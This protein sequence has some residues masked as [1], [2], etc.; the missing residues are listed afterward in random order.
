MRIRIAEEQDITEIESLYSQLFSAMAALQPDF[1]SPAFADRAFIRKNIEETESDILIA[2][3]NGNTE[4]FLLIQEKKTPPYDCFIPHRYAYIMDI[5][6]DEC[7][8]GKGVGTMLLQQARAWAKERN[9]EYIELGGLAG[10][11]GASRLYEKM[12]F[13]DVQK[14][15]RCRL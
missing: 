15:M 1:I 6:V 8:R 2:E 13:S 10:N 7:S 4:G 12:G 11:E 14:T 3:E 9:L 5:C